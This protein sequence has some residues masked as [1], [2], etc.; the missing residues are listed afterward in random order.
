MMPNYTILA[1][2]IEGMK[3]INTDDV[4]ITEQER[5]QEKYGQ[6]YNQALADVLAYLHQMAIMR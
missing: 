1:K 6:G 2:H 4:K 3:L 5:L